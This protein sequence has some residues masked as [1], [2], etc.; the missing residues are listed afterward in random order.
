MPER[1]EHDAGSERDPA[2]DGGERR[3]RDAE[4][5][6][7]V[8]EREV[9]AGPDRVVAE[10]LGELGDR[11]EAA[12]GRAARSASWPLP[13]IPIL[14]GPTPPTAGS[15]SRPSRSTARRNAR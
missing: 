1:K 2:R 9:L 5:E 10:L 13:W 15:P 14:I 3:E 6:D 11:P 12:R 7:R 8:V 4:V